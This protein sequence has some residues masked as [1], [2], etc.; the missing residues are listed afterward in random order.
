MRLTRYQVLLLRRDAQETVAFWRNRQRRHEAVINLRKCKSAKDLFRF[1]HEHFVRP[2]AQ[3]ESE[4]MRLVSTAAPMR[5]RVVCEI[6]VQDGGTNFIL[7][8]TLPTIDLMIGIDLHV[9]LKCQL[10]H[11]RRSDLRL[12][13]IDGPSQST[14]TRRRLERI[15]K[16][17]QLDLLFVDADHSYAGAMGDFLM[18]RHFVRD[19]GLIVF[20]DIIPDYY[21]RYGIR[22]EAC[23]GEVPRLWAELAPHFESEELVDDP[24]QDG[25]GIGLIHYDSTVTLPEDLVALLWCGAGAR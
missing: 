7:S 23:T 1:T 25:R 13:L 16:G 4:I 5:P 8:Q 10:R 15:L 21:T 11:F 12:R 18:Y 3:N 19:G 9:S 2:A 14:R 6:G 22:T 17:R 20:H 24:A